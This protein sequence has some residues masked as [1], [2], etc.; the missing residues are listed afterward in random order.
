MQQISSNSVWWKWLIGNEDS[1]AVH[2]KPENS[3][4][5]MVGKICG[6]G[7]WNMELLDVNEGLGIGMWNVEQQGPDWELEY[8]ISRPKKGLGMELE[9]GK[10]HV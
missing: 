7:L 10:F 6:M 5:K 3:F 4:A 1:H 9:Y 2:E 8:G